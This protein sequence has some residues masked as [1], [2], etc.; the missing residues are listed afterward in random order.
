M[1]SE[2]RNHGD[3]KRVAS[4]ILL[5]AAI[6]VCMILSQHS[7]PP[8]SAVAGVSGMAHPHPPLDRAPG[9]PLQ[10]PLLTRVS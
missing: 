10:V 9:Q 3:L 7:D 5:A 1:S 6:A 8:P 2:R 4:T